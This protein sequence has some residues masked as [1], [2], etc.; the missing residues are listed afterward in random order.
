MIGGGGDAAAKSETML[1]TLSH[2]GLLRF[3]GDD[4]R[5]FLHSQ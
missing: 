1:A 3:T 5:V 2:F 4:A